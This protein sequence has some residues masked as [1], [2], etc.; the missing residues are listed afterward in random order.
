MRQRRERQRENRGRRERAKGTPPPD[1][2]LRPDRGPRRGRPTGGG[3]VGWGVGREDGE[4][5]VEAPP[6]VGR[7]AAGR[8]A[9]TAAACV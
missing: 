7:R 4:V 6:A 9:A 2:L 1:K 8:G 3:G 5:V